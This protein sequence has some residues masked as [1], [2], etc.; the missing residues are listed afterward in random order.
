MRR[1]TFVL[2]LAV[3]TVTVEILFMY[4]GGNA[5][6]AAR[7]EHC[8]ALEDMWANMFDCVNSNFPACRAIENAYEKA[9]CG[10]LLYYFY[11]GFEA[12]AVGDVPT[13]W[14]IRDNKGEV[15][16]VDSPVYSDN[17]AV[18]VWDLLAKGRSQGIPTMEKIKV[19]SYIRPTV[20]DE[21]TTIG[22]TGIGESGGPGLAVNIQFVGD[23]RIRLGAYP[24]YSYILQDSYIGNT[25]YKVIFKADS[26]ADTITVWIDDD[27]KGTYPFGNLQDG[28]NGIIFRTDGRGNKFYLDDVTIEEYQ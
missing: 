7:D 4:E 13:G 12:N 28:L 10:A 2:I 24:G 5:A 18:E 3:L 11:D 26:T 27:P 21:W 22:V 25:W 1:F 23:G 20:T 8:A 6:M 15:K 17:R 19:T 14:T 16:V 9:R